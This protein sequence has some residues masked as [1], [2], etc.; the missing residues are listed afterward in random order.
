M[1]ARARGWFFAGDRCQS[2]ARPSFTSFGLGCSMG[3]AKKFAVDL[4][5]EMA[6]FTDDLRKRARGTPPFELTAIEKIRQL[7]QLRDEG[8]IAES[9]FQ[10]QKKR[11]LDQV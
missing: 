7:A 3:A 11:L 1:G 4:Q 8:I 6:V 2:K 5:E 9:E 10:E